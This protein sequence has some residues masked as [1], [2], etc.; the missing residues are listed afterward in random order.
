MDLDP[1]LRKRRVSARQVIDGRGGPIGKRNFYPIVLIAVLM[2][3]VVERP[4]LDLDRGR[5]R[6][7]IREVD[8]MARFAEESPAGFGLL[9][10][11][12]AIAR[13]GLMTGP[14]LRLLQEMVGASRGAI[15]ASGGMASIAD[16]RAVRDLG[17]AGAIIG[18]ALYEGTIDLADALRAMAD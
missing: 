2:P 13:D 3:P 1:F 9:F 14:D 7:V 10:A 12:T 17:C 6:E 4:C 11:V 8:E 18:R 15:I 5:V 16:V